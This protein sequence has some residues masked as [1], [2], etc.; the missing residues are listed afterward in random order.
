M[1]AIETG[2]FRIMLH[3]RLLGEVG[4]VSVGAIHELPLLDAIPYPL[5]F[6]GS[7]M[8]RSRVRS[9]PGVH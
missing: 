7:L 2:L 8:I 4:D 6:A 9:V 3:P 5:T 1:I